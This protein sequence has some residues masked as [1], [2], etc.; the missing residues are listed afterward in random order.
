MRPSEVANL[1]QQIVSRTR[2]DFLLSSASGIGAIGLGS[3]LAQDGLLEPAALA[4]AEPEFSSPLAAKKPHFEGPAKACIFIFMAGGPS[5]LDLF[6]RKPELVK[7]N[8]QPLPKSIYEG[9]RFAF[10]K[11]ETARLM[12]PMNRTWKKHGE[13]GM[14]LSDLLPHIGGV[15]DD[16][17]LI[18]SM[19]S[20]QF[21]H[22]P[23]QLL[24]QC[25]RAEFGLPVMGSWL[26]YGLGSES[27]N[28][29][30]YVVL[31]AGRGSSGGA[32]LWQSGFLPSVYEGVLFRPQGEPVLNLENP[33]GI[34]MELQRRGLDALNDLNQKRYQTIHD[35]EIASRI[36]SYELAFRMQ[37]AAPE[38]IDLS[39]ETEQ[40]LDE[41]GVNR[42]TPGKGGRGSYGSDT[43]GTF[44]RNCLLARRMVERGVRC[45]NI[46]HASWDHHSN[47]DP[48][49]DFNATMADQPIAAL[50][51]DLKQRGLLDSTMVVWGSEFGRTPLGENRGGNTNNVSG[52]D[53]H[54]F[55][56]SM[57]LAGGGFR[58]GQVYGKSD[59]L[60]WGV[61][62]N[63]VHANDLHA[64][65]LNRFGLDHLRLTHRFQGRDYRLTDVAGEV[66]EPLIT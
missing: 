8:G 15:A 9:V 29:P 33:K 28:L 30:G 26:T 66:I 43:F 6:D 61:A 19:Y 45:I 13:C 37:T 14:E 16:I 38:L 36:S 54:P 47:L 44:A 32:T 48:E 3:M 24:M 39:T 41:Y 2:R 12:G 50:I 56:Y 46:V 10:L 58:G 65:M 49:L 23:G 53:H 52:R 27:E 7:Q 1:Q 51:K 60:G 63:P 4:A 11:P 35:P 17:C 57:F 20:E 40:T 25:G 64:T 5:Q 31:T 18:R 59:E 62:E 34:S 55:S 42:K 21:N 22:H